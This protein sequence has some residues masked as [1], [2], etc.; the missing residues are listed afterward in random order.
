M[1]CTEDCKLGQV[2]D[3]S[4][5][6]DAAIVGWECVGGTQG[7]NA[8]RVLNGDY[9]CRPR[10]LGDACSSNVQC[11][12]ITGGICGN[13][14]CQC[15]AGYVL[16]GGACAPI[17]GVA[18]F[19]DSQCAALGGDAYTCFAGLCECNDGYYQDNQVG[20]FSFFLQLEYSIQVLFSIA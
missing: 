1:T 7:C 13:G 11:G 6:C 15:A 5:T 17:I 8:S 18:C 10:A 16:Q 12:E 9:F 14:I 4:L 19:L 2:C 3:A 20:Q